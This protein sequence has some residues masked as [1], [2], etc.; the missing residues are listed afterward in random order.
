VRFNV[1]GIVIAAA[2]FVRDREKCC[3]AAAAMSPKKS[4]LPDS[5]FR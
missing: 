4:F 3:G 2:R 1:T 5:H